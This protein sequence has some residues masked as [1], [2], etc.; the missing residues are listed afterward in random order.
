VFWQRSDA[1]VLPSFG[2]FTGGA[3]IVPAP[4]DRVYAVGPERV[5]ALAVRAD[6]PGP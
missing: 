2:F 5:V 4:G 6:Q 1:L 3:D